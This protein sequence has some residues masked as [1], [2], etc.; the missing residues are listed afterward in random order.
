MFWREN[1]L[2]LL[3]VT[4]SCGVPEHTYILTYLFAGGGAGNWNVRLL[5]IL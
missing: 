3:N 1:D 2:T 5:L 4:R